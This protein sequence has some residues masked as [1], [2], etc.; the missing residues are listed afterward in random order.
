VN[1]FVMIE[2]TYLFNCRSLTRSMFKIGLFTNPWV[3]VGSGAMIVLQLL[4]TYA[5]VMNRVFHS[6][7]ISLADW[8]LIAL[9]AVAVYVIIGLE[10]WVR[11]HVLKNPR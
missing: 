8:L 11:L 6:A 2:L 7:P 5:P 10:K 9:I 1:L 4:F 3:L